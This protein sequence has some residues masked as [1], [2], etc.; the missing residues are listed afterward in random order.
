MASPRQLSLRTRNVSGWGRPSDRQHL[1]L[2]ANEAHTQTEE[3][4]CGVGGRAGSTGEIREVSGE[5]TPTSAISTT[6]AVVGGPRS[7]RRERCDL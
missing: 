3:E 6:W 5:P 2:E 7:T 4:R 1:G